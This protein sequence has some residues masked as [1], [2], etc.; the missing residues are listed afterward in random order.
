MFFL[1]EKLFKCILMLFNFYFFRKYKN[2]DFLLKNNIFKN[3][4][5]TFKVLKNIMRK[6]F[7]IYYKLN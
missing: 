1:H 4:L 6:L 7:M 5:L 2:N 3:D